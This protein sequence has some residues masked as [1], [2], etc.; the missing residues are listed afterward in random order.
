MKTANWLGS[1]ALAYSLL[2]FAIGNSDYTFIGSPY[3]FLLLSVFPPLALFMGLLGFIA[4]IL[5]IKIFIRERKFA[6]GLFLGII[7]L[8]LICLQYFSVS[9]ASNS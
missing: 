7:S 3:G 5:G 9:V 6:I 2:L 1:L 4:I 8:V